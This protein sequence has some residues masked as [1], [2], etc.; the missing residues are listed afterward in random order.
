MTSNSISTF[1]GNPVSTVAASAVLEVV[2]SR[3]IQSNAAKLG[4]SLLAGLRDLAG[5]CSLIG[6]VRGKGLMIG[7]ELVDPDGYAHDA[8]AAAQVLEETRR[9]GL[10]VGKGGL[11]GN[12]LRIAPPLSLSESEADEGLGI[13]T[14]ALESVDRDR[15]S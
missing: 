13:L 5:R 6:E 11:Y 8:T 1:G 2:L 7:I 14:A 10:L 15:R 3:D 12:V 9:L 4:T